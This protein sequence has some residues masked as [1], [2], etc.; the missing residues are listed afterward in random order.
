MALIGLRYDLRHHFD[1]GVA[2]APLYQACV[3]QCAWA[4]SQVALD[5]R[6]HA[7][8]AVCYELLLV[9]FAP[10]HLEDL[11]LTARLKVRARL[12]QA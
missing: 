1:G 8:L 7:L 3:Q 4:D 10:N 5:R 12:H 9:R 6:F 2:S 11:D